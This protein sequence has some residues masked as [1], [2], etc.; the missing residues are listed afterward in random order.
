V[1]RVILGSTWAWQTTTS[2]PRGLFSVVAGGPVGEFVQVNFNGFASLALKDG[3]VRDLPPDVLDVY[4][5]PFLPLDRRGIAAFYPGQITAATDYFVEVEAG[6]PHLADKPALI[7]WALQDAGFPRADLVRFERTFPNHK[8]IELPTLNHFFFED[9][10]A[11]MIPEIRAF[12]AS[13]PAGQA[14]APHVAEIFSR[15]TGQPHRF[16]EMPLEY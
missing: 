9:A 8:T 12:M 16:G 11:E 4:T 7:F 10:A 13:D 14:T 15:I 3:I 5:R 1:R 6:L 2:E